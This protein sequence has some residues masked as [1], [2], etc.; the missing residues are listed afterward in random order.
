MSVDTSPIELVDELHRRQGDMYGGGPIEP[1]L[2]LLPPDIVWHVPGKSP[3]SGDHR[4]IRQVV[5]YLERRRQL[6]KD[7]MQMQP[8]EVICEGDAVA[9]F[10]EGTAVLAGEQV[11]WQ[12]I[13]VYRVDLDHRW[14]RE[15][16]LVPLD[17]DLFDR[18]WGSAS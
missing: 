9:Q 1:V 13:G 12:T 18:I 11:S 4:G 8:G 2:E 5:D 14:V 17:S 15:V 3:I 10:V 6:A 7:T 16:W